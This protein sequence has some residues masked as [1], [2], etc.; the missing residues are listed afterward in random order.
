MKNFRFWFF[1]YGTLSKLGHRTGHHKCGNL[2]LSFRTSYPITF[3]YPRNVLYSYYRKKN[4]KQKASETSRVHKINIHMVAMAMWK[5]AG[6]P[7]ITLYP[8]GNLSMSIL[9]TG[10]H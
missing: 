9:K 7:N 2:N 5:L 1:I 8:A 3:Y 6:Q 4:E 10:S